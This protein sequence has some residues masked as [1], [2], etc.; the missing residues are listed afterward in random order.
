VKLYV[1]E[2]HSS[3]V[4][5][6]V[7]ESEIVA[8]CR[9]AYPE[10]I[11]ALNRRLRQGDLSGKEYDLLVSK[12]SDDWNHFAAIDFDEL[13][14]GRFVSLYGLRSFDAIHLSA[15]KLLKAD[16][17]NISISFSSFD[18]KLNSAASSEGL[19]VLTLG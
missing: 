9:I 3:S 5:K 10:T 1:K 16:S 2:A 13:E 4:R 12:F 7:K 19:S 15:V 8:S 11:S 14:A 6:W 17:N 18:E